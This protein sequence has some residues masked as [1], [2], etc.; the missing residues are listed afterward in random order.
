MFVYIFLNNKLMSIN[1]EDYF[2]SISCNV[3]NSI[4]KNFIDK[5]YKFMNKKTQLFKK[6]FLNL[7]KALEYYKKCRM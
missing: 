3:E 2:K 7:V 6:N 5:K 4:I 1:L